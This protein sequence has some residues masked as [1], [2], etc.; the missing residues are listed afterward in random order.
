MSDYDKLDEAQ[1]TLSL[2][3][4]AEK[5]E[6]EYT[7]EEEMAAAEKL[8]EE[9]PEYRK[10]VDRGKE[11]NWVDMAPKELLAGATSRFY[12]PDGTPMPRRLR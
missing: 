11:S 3:Q 12:G 6:V 9:Y 7:S 10:Q 8:Y 2:D 1:Y 5:L 4:L